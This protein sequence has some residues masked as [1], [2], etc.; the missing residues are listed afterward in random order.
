MGYLSELRLGSPLEPLSIFGIKPAVGNRESDV[1]QSAK[2]AV[3]SGQAPPMAIALTSFSPRRL[4]LAAAVGILVVTLCVWVVWSL[5]MI[6]SRGAE[7]RCP[8]CASRRVRQ[9]WL[10]VLDRC[11]MIFQP[12]R[13]E[14]CLRRFY[15]L[16]RMES[17]RRVTGGA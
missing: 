10:R 4:A 2:V 1:L 6:A 9:A 8:H 14:A 5:V 16:K 13:C 15:L 17:P 7:R 12:F 3:L 11:L